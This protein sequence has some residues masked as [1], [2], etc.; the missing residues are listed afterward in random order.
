MEAQANQ[1]FF[2]YAGPTEHAVAAAFEHTAVLT[3]KPE[4]KNPLNK[5]GRMFGRIMYLLDSYED[6]ADDIE[7]QTFNALAASYPKKEWQTRAANI[8][9]QAHEELAENVQRLELSR[10]GL[11]HA[12]LIRKLKRKGYG[13]IPI[14]KNISDN[15]RLSGFQASS[16][17]SMGLDKT[18]RQN[19]R[20][21]KKKKSKHSSRKSWC[22]DCCYCDCDCLPECECCDCCSGCDGCCCDC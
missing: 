2:L 18:V 16:A 21:G 13:T 22:C 14:F 3:N 4:N 17:S 5:A 6:Y 10:P 1:N 20:K 15:Y 9:Q 11:I 19:N 7:T 8:F 12:L